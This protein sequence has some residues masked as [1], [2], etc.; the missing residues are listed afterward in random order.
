MSV[1]T[2]TA[3]SLALEPMERMAGTAMAVIGMVSLGGGAVL[4]AVFDRL[5][6]DTVTPMAVAFSVYGT[7]SA[8]WMRWAGRT[9]PA[10][11]VARP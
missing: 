1:V 5:I 6:D 4:A 9:V 3:L 7:M 2:P 10:S 8:A 11:A